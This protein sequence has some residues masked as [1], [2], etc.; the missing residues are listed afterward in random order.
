MPDVLALLYANLHTL[1]AWYIPNMEEL[2]QILLP[3][4]RYRQFCIFKSVIAVFRT[5]FM[6]FGG[7]LGTVSGGT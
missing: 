2:H 1:S 6:Q 5:V 4:I 7:A 3:T